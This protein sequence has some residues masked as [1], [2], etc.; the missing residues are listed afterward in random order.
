MAIQRSILYSAALSAVWLS[1]CVSTREGFCQKSANSIAPD[2][3]INIAVQT[4]GIKDRTKYKIEL[5]EGEGDYVGYIVY[6]EARED[7]SIPSFGSVTVDYCGK[8]WG[9][10]RPL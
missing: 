3:A 7:G 9:V 1:G 8:V 4:V 5:S 10:S 2:A 6:Y